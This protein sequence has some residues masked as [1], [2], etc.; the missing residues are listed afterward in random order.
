MGERLGFQIIYLFGTVFH[1]TKT[2]VTKNFTD[3]FGSKVGS[4]GFRRFQKNSADVTSSSSHKV[5]IKRNWT[6]STTSFPTPQLRPPKLPI[7]IHS[8]KFGA[9]HGHR[10]GSAT[11]NKSGNLRGQGAKAKVQMVGL[12]ISR[13]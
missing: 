3:D 6:H 10:R 12:R 1:M 13:M 5:G 4:Y 11:T 2:T 9:S 8:D 7:H